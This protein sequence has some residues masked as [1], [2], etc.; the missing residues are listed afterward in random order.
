M[1]NEVP[2]SVGGSDVV[3]AQSRHLCASVSIV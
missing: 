3:S 2:H 1:G